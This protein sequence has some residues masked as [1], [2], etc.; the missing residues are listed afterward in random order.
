MD[1][2]THLVRNDRGAGH[3]PCLINRIL[4]RMQDWTGQKNTFMVKFRNHI[5][6]FE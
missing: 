4:Q 3:K 1:Y 2:I 6:L 5:M